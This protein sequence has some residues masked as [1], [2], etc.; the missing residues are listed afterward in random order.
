[1]GRVQLCVAAGLERDAAQVADRPARGFQDRRDEVDGRRLAVGAGYADC[2]ESTSGK[3]PERGGDSRQRPSSVVNDDEG[4][5]AAFRQGLPLGLPVRL[6]DDDAGTSVERRFDEVVT[7]AT[8]WRER[9]RHCDECGALRYEAGV[10]ADGAY[11]FRRSSENFD[12]RRNRI[13]ID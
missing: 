8:A 10:I 9:P 1:V 4:R 13:P 11:G 3:P 5:S 2:H 6:H 7:V 12:S